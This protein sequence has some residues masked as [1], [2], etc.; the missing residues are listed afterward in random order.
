MVKGEYFIGAM[1]F[2]YSIPYAWIFFQVSI[3]M[4]A[5]ADQGPLFVIYSFWNIGIILYYISKMMQRGAA[6]NELDQYIK[7]VMIR[8]NKDSARMQI[9]ANNEQVYKLKE[10][11]SEEETG[12][13][14]IYILTYK[15]INGLCAWT[16][17]ADGTVYR[18]IE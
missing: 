15:K 12:V 3:R 8:L 16:D 2:V 10:C 5:L 1:L 11:K 6:V 14:K 7:R 13:P 17:E 18:D 9:L 4:Q